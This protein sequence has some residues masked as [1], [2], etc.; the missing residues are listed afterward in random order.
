MSPVALVTGASRGIGAAIAK[1][2]ALDGADIIVQYRTSEEEA[3]KVAQAIRAVG[4]EALVVQADVRDKQSLKQM[5]DLLERAGW[6]P[7][8]VVHSA[9][10]A[11]YGLLNDMEDDE[12]DD[13]MD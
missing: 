1:A 8:I 7:T 13:L 10:A 3:G 5:K 6:S 9:G 12:W 2:L 4:R 11:Y